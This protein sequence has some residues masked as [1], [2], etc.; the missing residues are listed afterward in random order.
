MSDS[1]ETL[2]QTYTQTNDP[3]ASI[4]KELDAISN[5]PQFVQ[6]EIETETSR[7]QNQMDQDALYFDGVMGELDS[8]S[9]AEPEN[10]DGEKKAAKP[11]ESPTQKQFYETIKQTYKNMPGGTVFAKAFADNDFGQFNTQ[12]VA[13]VA[14]AVQGTGNTILAGADY[15][16]DWLKRKG[17]TKEEFITKDTKLD[18]VEKSFPS[19]T[20]MTDKVTRSVAKY[21]I[22]TF[23]AR[24]AVA[25]AGSAAAKWGRGAAA[26]AGFNFIAVDPREERLSNLVQE[27]GPALA[28]PLAQILAAD[29]DDGEL[30]SRLKNA[31]EG[32]LVD[33]GVAG[34]LS[35]MAKAYKGARGV[36]SAILAK[37]EAEAVVKATKEFES[38]A[39][40]VADVPVNKEVVSA[41]PEAIEQSVKTGKPTGFKV[42]V[43]R[44][45]DED[46]L[47]GFIKNYVKENSESINKA[48]GGTLSDQEL[49]AKA[50]SISADPM[51]KEDLL[52]RALKPGMTVTPEEKLVI[53]G[54]FVD[55]SEQMQ[56]FL[57]KFDPEKAT[58]P[59]WK[60]FNDYVIGM[61]KLSKA[62]YSTSATAGRT[63]RATQLVSD[64][65]ASKKAKYAV[66]Q[67]KLMGGEENLKK[68]AYALKD[69]ADRPVDD[70]VDAA[71]KI[72]LKS[73]GKKWFDA[74]L[75]VRMNGIL[76][77]GKTFVTG[78]V[79][80]MLVTGPAAIVER[81]IG[82]IWSVATGAKNG[83][84]KGE[85]GQMVAAYKSESA[86]MISSLYG[87][88]E[89]WVMQAANSI[90]DGEFGSFVSAN[91][92]SGFQALK[93][94]GRE[95]PP[96]MKFGTV[97]EANDLTPAI[98]SKH[99]GL[100]PESSLGTL[101]DVSGAIT[102]APTYAL[103]KSDQMVGQILYNMEKRALA[104]REIANK[105][106]DITSDEGQKIF[107]KLTSDMPENI[108]VPWINEASKNIREGA[109]YFS[110][111]SKFTTQLEGTAAQID[112]LIK[113]DIYGAPWL[114]MFLPF[115][116]VELNMISYGFERFPGLALMSGKV[117]SELAAGGATAAMA[118]AKQSLGAM[119][120]MSGGVMAYN[121]LITGNGPKNADM[122]KL[123][124][125]NGWQ[126][127]SVKIG[128]TY[129][130][131]DRVGD[132]FSSFLSF[133]ADMADIS[134]S[135]LEA[136][137]QEYMKMMAAAAYAFADAMTPEFLTR[138][139]A[140][141]LEAANPRNNNTSGGQF[142]L[143]NLVKGQIPFSA[144]LRDV[145]RNGMPFGLTDGDKVVRETFANPDSPFAGLIELKNSI[146]NDLPYFSES[147]PPRRNLWGEPVVYPSAM[148]PDSFSPIAQ[149]KEPIG[150][151][152]AVVD[153]MVRLGVAG[154]A[155][156]PE[157]PEGEQYL[158]IK[159][160]S[161][162]VK[163]SIAGQTLTVNLS[164]EQYDKY[165]QYSAGIGLKPD[166]NPTGRGLT[167][168]DA[169][170]E[171]IKSNWPDLGSQ[172]NDQNKRI[173]IGK[174]VS[175]YRQ[176]AA[177][178]LQLEDE[179]FENKYNNLMQK[180]VMSRSAIGD[181]EQ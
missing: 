55:V 132:P 139:M 65:N 56:N 78:V 32:L 111:K 46:D 6:Q 33:A 20:E 100:D 167:L 87:G 99:F 23:A 157:A 101:V 125:Q 70:F 95:A 41:A 151:R 109:E 154:K 89:D 4:L 158:I 9:Q 44:L 52:T 119:F 165:V 146:V 61:D 47:K 45:T 134:E 164:P 62:S 97:L 166:F 58:A 112:Q 24:G 169:I 51:A 10:V 145:R 81:G 176:A 76:S 35:L 49:I 43:E 2:G 60:E 21:L 17:L 153:E 38:V 40:K 106:I 180:A 181:V 102:R 137:P 160:A 133:A 22:P 147:L 64:M 110:N 178:Q 27:S 104:I 129:Y 168:E 66:E 57:K 48:R 96:R 105:G 121:G 171:Q 120:L 34:G 50:Q 11:T 72:A 130:R 86:R 113:S 128:D 26:A 13:S 115:A 150:K 74:A 53:D 103:T 19:P 155:Y 63:L 88:F 16:D 117:R 122:R 54:M 93:K 131:H 114:R 91:G 25:K 92:K 162:A 29:K 173:Y 172:K 1:L 170:H 5:D 143:T 175:V 30:E 83:V 159:Q 37:K 152:K 12:V 144:L 156:H 18:F 148:G 108:E 136:K 31:A 141:L 127:N 80:P 135:A 84:A 28:R 8:I 98:S 126:P 149:M 174:L 68:M 7:A 163:K 138:N 79:S 177:A 107:S 75:E 94:M 124:E 179:G 36:Q 71:G 67:I 42:N 116:R 3:N 69:M 123:M 14:D 90:R 118:K 15:V 82:R 73:T 77:S 142:L 85:V 39:V 59:Q 161:R 140:D